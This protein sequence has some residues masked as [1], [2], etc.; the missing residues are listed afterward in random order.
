MSERA[1]NDRS[2]PLADIDRERFPAWGPTSAFGLEDRTEIDPE[3]T[4][5]NS[6]VIARCKKPMP[7]FKHEEDFA[8]QPIYDDE[9][10]APF[11]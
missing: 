1:A 11:F 5:G 7:S 4:F 8:V 10:E 9:P 2:P 6:R 3:A